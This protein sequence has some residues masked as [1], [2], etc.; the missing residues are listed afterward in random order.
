MTKSLEIV[1]VQGVSINPKVLLTLYMEAPYLLQLLLLLE[2]IC[3]HPQTLWPH[4]VTHSNADGQR[5]RSGDE[6]AGDP[7]SFPHKTLF[8]VAAAAAPPPRSVRSSSPPP[9]MLRIEGSPGRPNGPIGRRRH[10]RAEGA[11]A[12]EVASSVVVATT[13]ALAQDIS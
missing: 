10:R 6:A 3:G 2:D 9:Q 11:R 13:D 4:T 7:S 8:A 5:G 1:E 12:V